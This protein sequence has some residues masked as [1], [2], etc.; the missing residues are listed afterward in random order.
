[1]SKPVTVKALCHGLSA[2]GYP[3]LMTSGCVGQ[4]LN[5]SKTLKVAMKWNS[6][7]MIGASQPWVFF[8]EAYDT[9]SLF[10]S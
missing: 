4:L 9:A 7:L 8:L 3:V 5:L 6:Y 10:P 1:M 2:A